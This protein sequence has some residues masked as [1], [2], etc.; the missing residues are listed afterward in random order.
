MTHTSKS[1]KKS[2]ALA[3]SFVTNAETVCVKTVSEFHA[4]AHARRIMEDPKTMTSTIQFE[5]YAGMFPCNGREG[6]KFMKYN[7]HK[8]TWSKRNGSVSHLWELRTVHGAIHFHVN[9]YRD[10]EPS[11]G[12]ERH[13]VYPIGENAPDHINCPFTGGRCWH[14][15]TSLYAME[16]LWPRIRPLLEESCH[17]SIFGILEREADILAEYITQRTQ[18]A[19]LP[20][21]IQGDG[22]EGEI[23]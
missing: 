10:N 7:G 15:G 13:S 2:F 1:E 4:T 16:T 21:L 22:R 19:A 8:Y 9:F 3:I 14:D 18:A 11:C 5:R 12:L 23:L 17:E 6:F 20:H